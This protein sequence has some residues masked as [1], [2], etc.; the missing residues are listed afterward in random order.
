MLD[1]KYKGTTSDLLHHPGKQGA[2]M[3]YS[4]SSDLGAGEQADASFK[5]MNAS[6]NTKHF[7]D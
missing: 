2:K 1:F 3:P 5:G 7:W 6:L 4:S